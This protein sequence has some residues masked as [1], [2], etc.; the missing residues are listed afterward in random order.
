VA[1]YT[2]L[3]VVKARLGRTDARDDTTIAA[4][5]T[6]ASRH[7]DQLCNRRFDQTTATRYFTPTGSWFT[8]IDDLVSV[9][10]L[11]T[12]LQGDRTYGETWQTTDYELEPINAAGLGRPYTR[13]EIAPKGTKSFPVLRR[14][15]EI[16]GVWGFPAVPAAVTE[17]TTLLAIRLLKRIDAPFGIVGSTDLG[18]FIQLGKD[19]DIGALLSPYRRMTLGVI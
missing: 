5:V 2:T 12:D 10:T 8:E 3:E 6:A 7:V 13:I 1:D 16:A 11:K 14:G 19:P 15:V 17:A 18:G 4:I 9:T